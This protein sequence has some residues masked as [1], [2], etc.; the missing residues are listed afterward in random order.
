[1][2]VPER[3]NDFRV[4]LEGT[5]DLQGVADIQLPSFDSIVDTV[6]GAGIAGEYESPVLGHFQSMKLTLNWRTITRD[7]VKLMHQKAQRFDCRGA[8]QE[9]DSSMGEYKIKRTRVVVHGVSTSNNPGQL[10]K[11]SA[12]N[13]SNAI[14]VLYIKIDIDGRNYVELDKMNYKCVID[15]IDYLSD[16]RDA[17]GL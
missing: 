12:S 13:G 1:M 14:E 2:T 3:L 17:L 9:Y 11:G 15:G 8:F 16:V 5:N 4:Y 10:A 6:S 7:N